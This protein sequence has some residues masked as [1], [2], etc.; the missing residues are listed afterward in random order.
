[1]RPAS[2]TSAA[3][4]P[5]LEWV[6]KV[7][8]T[9][10]HSIVMS[11]RNVRVVVG[12]L[13]EIGHRPNEQHRGSAV[14][15]GSRSDSP[16]SSLGHG[17]RQAQHRAEPDAAEVIVADACSRRVDGMAASLSIEFGRRRDKGPRG[18]RGCRRVARL[19]GRAPVVV[20]WCYQLVLTGGF[21]PD[22]SQLDFGRSRAGEAIRLELPIFRRI[23]RVAARGW[24]WSD[25]RSSC[26]NHGWLSP[27]VA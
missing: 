13:G 8:R 23:R 19:V 11:D 24:V 20:T 14:A 3:V 4:K 15:G 7:S 12:H 26:G 9:R 5:P 16:S 21:I 25:G 17:L 18:Q 1:M 22:S 10:F 27:D 2:A 6:D